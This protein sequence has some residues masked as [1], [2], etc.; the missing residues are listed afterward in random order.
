MTTVNEAALENKFE[1]IARIIARRY[2]IIVRLRGGTAYVDL[3]AEPPAINLPSLNLG[4]TIVGMRILPWMLDGF[5]D[6]EVAHVKF[7]TPSVVK[8]AVAD[9]SVI[10]DLWNVIEDM[11]IERLMAAEYI[12]C[13]HNLDRLRVFMF[14]KYDREWD[15]IDPLGKLAYVIQ[16]VMW[17]KAEPAEF[18][19][20]PMIGPLAMLIEDEMLAGRTTTSS[21]ECLELARAIYKK[22]GDEASKMEPKPGKGKGTGDEEGE[23]GLASGEASGESEGSDSAAGPETEDSDGDKQASS[24]GV[25]EEGDEETEADGEKDVTKT[26]DADSVTEAAKDFKKAERDGFEEPMNVESMVNDHIEEIFKEE[27]DKDP[28]RYV[29]FSEEWDEPKTFSLEER[30]KFGPMYERLKGEVNSYIGTMSSTLEMALITDM[31]RRLAP[32]DRRGRKFD[33]RRLTRWME[34]CGDDRI[35]KRYETGEFIDTAVSLLWDGSGSM[36]SNTNAKNKSA[37]ARIAAIA[38]HEALKRV[39]IPHEVLGFDSGGGTPA[40]LRDAVRDAEARGENLDRYS[41]TDDIDNLYV[42]KGFDDDDPRAICDI[43]GR[44]ANRDG[45]AVLW[46][47]RRLAMRPEPR[48]VLIV[49]SDGMPSGARYYKT[50]KDYLREVVLRAIDAGIE[51]YAIGIMTEHVKDYYPEWLA[52]HKAADLPKAVMTQLGR[53]LLTRKGANNAGGYPTAAVL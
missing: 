13:G 46:A 47:A 52:I 8:T 21:I 17:N 10:K 14:E 29:V 41:R 26:P 39:N 32:A 35:Y 25:K 6:H 24:T 37:L 48:K 11:M 9:G 40:G 49:G 53:A 3:E 19:S 30:R 16:K 22:L 44:A 1:K 34:D 28:D 51:V 7:T 36:G 50:E 43:D 42:F 23:A 38:F 2:G 5:I 45:E 15:T 27:T 20:L 31:E 12:G 4:E 33:R 18:Y